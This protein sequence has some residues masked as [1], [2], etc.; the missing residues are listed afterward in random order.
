M[1]REPQWSAGWRLAAS[2][3]IE[4]FPASIYLQRIQIHKNTKTQK[5]K[6]IHIQKN[7]KYTHTHGTQNIHK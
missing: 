6:Q 7:T 3:Y 5:H 1:C 2:K 4:R